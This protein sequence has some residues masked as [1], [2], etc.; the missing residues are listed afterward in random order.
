MTREVALIVGAGLGLSASLARLCARQGMA[1][2]LAARDIAKLNSLT[3]ETGS[4]AYACDATEPAQVTQLFSDVGRD[5]G[6]P[7]LVVFNASQRVRGAV[8]DLDPAAVHRA[9]DVSC[10][11][12]FLVGRAAANIMLKR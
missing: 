8:A 3:A 9:L 5:L 10:F 11:A 6:D 1:V 2:A 7:G 12:G 4:S